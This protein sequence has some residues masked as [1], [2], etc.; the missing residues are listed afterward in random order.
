MQEN[1]EVPWWLVLI[2]GISALVIG[3]FLL[4]APAATTLFLVQF[5]GIYWLVSGIFQIV[6]IFIDKSAWGWKLF[7]GLLGI[8][9]GFA[10]IN[11][12]L[13]STV[14]VPT[15]LVIILGIQ[16][17]VV[18]GIGLFSAFKGGGWGAGVMAALS[19]IFGVLLLSSPFIAALALPWIFGI[20]A[21][22]GGIL[23]IVAAFKMK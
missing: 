7:S 12:P 22:L 8:L 14:L 3:F 11:H 16:G 10:V 19:I 21:V 15:T 20:F 13:W 23:G 1:Y 6:A 9:A 2:Q 18:G 5:L 17:L 4:T